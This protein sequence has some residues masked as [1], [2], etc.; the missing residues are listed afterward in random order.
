[1]LS[2]RRILIVITLLI[3]S[4]GFSASAAAQPSPDDP[5]LQAVLQAFSIARREGYHFTTKAL[6]INTYTAGDGTVQRQYIGL[7]QEGDVSAND[8]VQQKTK[9]TVG[10]T[11]EALKAFTPITL[12]SVAFGN[13]LYVYLDPQDQWSV[14]IF[15]VKPGWWRFADF[16]SQVSDP[17]VRFLVDNTISLGGPADTIDSGEA[18][19]SVDYTG[20]DHMDDRE[21]RIYLLQH[22]VL[23]TLLSSIPGEGSE[24]LANVLKYAPL[25][26]SSNL[27]LSLELRIGAEDGRLYYG[28]MDSRRGV[29][30]LSAGYGSEVPYDTEND[31]ISE[32]TFT[33]PFKP[34][35]IT[36]PDSSL[37]NH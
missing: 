33:Y 17:S 2:V 25:F 35:T 27:S 26:L 19:L 22:N 28:F 36:P 16:E 9:I 12:L 3:L 1:M 11:Q 34:V 23:E 24:H 31:S 5:D 10:G 7:E 8:D 14:G 29:P 21:L 15:N 4:V 18:V 6:T 13:H 30:Y 20:T 37:L 32:M